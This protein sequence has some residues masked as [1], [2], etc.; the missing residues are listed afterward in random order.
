VRTPVAEEIA[1]VFPEP[2]SAPPADLIELQA[3]SNSREQAEDEATGEVT[4]SIVDDFGLYRNAEHGLI[5]GEVGREIHS[6]RA[7]D[8]L[9]AR[10]TTHW[11][12]E[13]QRDDILLRTETWSTMQSTAGY[14]RLTARIEAWHNEK[15]VF[16]RDF[17]EDIE[18]DLN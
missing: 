12:Q 15:L 18:R 17:A 14:F 9:S 11:K 6:V 2:V 1:P 7:N 8:P 13:L 10:M 3:P 5:T 4:I 16:E